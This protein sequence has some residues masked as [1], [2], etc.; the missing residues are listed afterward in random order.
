MAKPS[1]HPVARAVALAAALLATSLVLAAAGDSA[2]AGDAGTS[3]R[4][5]ARVVLDAHNAYP[6]NGRHLD[7]IDR[8]LAGGVP[9]AIE[10]DLVW[11]PAGPD[12]PARSVVS[13]GAP[14]DGTEPSLR[15][16]FFERI[17]PIVE[18]ALA[19]GDR[20][21]WPLVVLNLDLKTNEPEHHRALWTLLGEYESWLTTAERTADASAPA[22]L[23]VGPVLVLTGESDEQARAFH[24]DLPVGSRLRLFGAMPI[25]P[26]V[27]PDDRRAAEQQRFWEALPLAPLPTATNY[28]RWWNAPWAVVEN[29]G[30][31]A[32]GEWTTTDEARLRTLVTRAHDAG[33]WLRLWT[34]NGHPPGA[35]A[36]EGW[37]TGYNVGSMEAAR[38]RWRAA[39]AAGVDFV[40]TDQYESF[41]AELPAG[42]RRL[43]AARDIVL[44]GTL[45]ASDRLTWIERPFEVPPGTARLDVVMTYADRE[46]GTAIEFGAYDPQRFR[47]ASRTSKTA[48]FIAETAATP[49]YQPGPLV[50]GTWRL[51]MGIPSIRDGVRSPYRIVVRLTPAG[52]GQPSPT[53]VPASRA[54]SGPRWYQGDLHAHTMH[55]DGFQC[56]DGR[57]GN[58]PC[59]AHLVASAAERRGLDFAAVTDHNTTSHHHGLVELQARH[60]DLLVLRG[61]EVTTFHGHANVFGTSEVIDFRIG[62]P[63]VTAASVFG[64]ARRLG[65]LVAI[66]HPGRET[67]ETCTGCGWDAPHTDYT[68]V[69]AIEVVNG[70]NVSGP[71]AGEPFWHARLNEGHRLTGI[72]GGDDHGGATRQGSAVGTPTTVIHAEGLSEAALLAGIR[73]GRVYIKTRGP[74]GP[75][76]RFDVPAHQATMGDVVSLTGP[77][78]IV[79]RTRVIG[80]AGQ[81]VDIIKNGLVQADAARHALTSNDEAREIALD[82]KPGDWVR[83]NVRDEAG[84]T[85]MGNPVYF[86]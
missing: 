12:G 21:L 56:A 42:R 13:H 80:A 59:A 14:F 2:P 22:S 70:R 54:M 44:E 57:G 19:D 84:I 41:L 81:S 5:G 11:R 1:A 26:P 73:A 24:D 32:A 28:R 52:P 47:G 68:L 53:A 17:R 48:F 6:Y 3:A 4:P 8:A 66:N 36:A 27:V 38:A 63:G 71:T 9:V 37:S 76:L 35:E 16:H 83:V 30:Q 50:P 15:D 64:H 85:V 49:S 29:A 51:L 60:P 33:L 74:L 31:R 86:R 43:V 55:S 72:G 61:Q 20:S 39:I 82:V 34:I 79:F 67:G 62:H 77:A 23:T 69:D 65:A 58:G 25:R 18:R 78:R 46:R 40:A 45:A 75:D 7:R 10:Q